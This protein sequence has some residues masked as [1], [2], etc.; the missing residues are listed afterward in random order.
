MTSAAS[1]FASHARTEPIRFACKKEIRVGAYLLQ[2][3][4][5]MRA[6]NAG[7][8]LFKL[9]TDWAEGCLGSFNAMDINKLAGQ[10]LILCSCKDPVH[11][12]DD[13]RCPIH[14]RV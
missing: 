12:G 11:P 14:G 2:P 10:E 9:Y 3:G 1:I 4:D 7:Y 5:R 13:A 6:V 8:G